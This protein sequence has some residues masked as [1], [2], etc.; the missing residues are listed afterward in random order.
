GAVLEAAKL[1]LNDPAAMR[2][3]DTLGGRVVLLGGSYQAGRDRYPTPVGMLTGVE[4]LAHS[5][6]TEL[7]PIT[8]LSE[9]L[10]WIDVGLGALLVVVGAFYRRLGWILTWIAAAGVL[11]ASYW[12]FRSAA[13]LFNA[14]PI[15]AA[16]LLHNRLERVWEAA[17]LR[18]RPEHPK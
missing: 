17:H 13:I 18:F 9:M 10:T 11:L 2:M 1:P 16:V 3:W 7:A 8:E 5:I 12:L 15:L 4:I 14:I 6:E